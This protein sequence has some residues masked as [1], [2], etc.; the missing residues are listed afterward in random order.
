MCGKDRRI[1][2][3]LTADYK[4]A[5]WIRFHTGILA[6][7]YFLSEGQPLP[8]KG[9][10]RWMPENNGATAAVKR[11]N[12]EDHVRLSR[13]G[14]PLRGEE[15]SQGVVCP[16]RLVGSLGRDIC[17]RVNSGGARITRC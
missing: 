16:C 13:A 9:K 8:F 14:A 1:Y 4:R 5:P 2:G 12:A 15:G 3:Y 17:V 11:K 10:P 6:A 7:P